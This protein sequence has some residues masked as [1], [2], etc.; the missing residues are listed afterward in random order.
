MESSH[1]NPE[2]LRLARESRGYTQTE[3][4]RRSRYAQSVISRFENG[5]LPLSRENV[6]AFARVLNYPLEFFE[7]TD[8]RYGLGCSFLFHRKRQNMPQHELRQIE[9]EVNVVRMQIDRL[10]RAV[11]MEH[12]NEFVA[13]DVDMHGGPEQIAQLVRA[14][15][16]LPA[17]PIQN[18]TRAIESAGGIVIRLP[19]PSRKL[20]GLSAW[21]TGLPAL[22]FLNNKAPG[23]R[24]RWTL[25]HELGH[26]VM[27][28]HPTPDIEGEANRFATELLMPAHEIKV[29]LCN[30]TLAKAAG[31]KLTWRVSMQALIRRA[32][33]LGTIAPGRYKSLFV[34]LSRA[35]YR[36]HEPNELEPE[37]G[38]NLEGILKFHQEEYGYSLDDIARLA[39]ALPDDFQRRMIPS[40][41][42]HLRIAQ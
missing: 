8:T 14:G 11:D 41:E 33:T 20:D 30:M 34:Q 7:Q 26:V 13:F 21:V 4:A 9:A 10:L 18:L 32:K 28:R 25:A 16:R 6:R 36:L 17:G 12:E 38:S 22:F 3:L 19:L 37:T 31:L 42:S 39:N 1:F 24:A 15:W 23:D 5:S 27:H 40:P 35:G 2:M 29:D